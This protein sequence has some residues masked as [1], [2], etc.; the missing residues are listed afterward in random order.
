MKLDQEYILHFGL[1]G[2]TLP[3][4]KSIYLTKK[5]EVVDAYESWARDTNLLR[6]YTY[7][8][9]LESEYT[10]KEKVLSELC[11]KD[12]EVCTS[13][14]AKVEVS[15]VVRDQN[16]K[17]LSGILLEVLG[18]SFTTR[19]D[20]N[21][22]YS[23]SFEHL[24][25]AVLRLSATSDS[26]MVGIKRLDIQDQIR[27]L[28]TAQKFI[29]DFTLALP[30]ATLRI[31][32]VA[33]TITGPWTGKWDTGYTVVTPSNKYWIPFDAIVEEN[34]V[35]YQGK[36][37][38]LL[39]EFDRNTSS[40][41]LDADVFDGVE[42]FAGQTLV[43]YGMP[44]IIFMGEKGEKLHVLNT[45]PMKI[46]TSFKEKDENT[47]SGEFARLYKLAYEDSQK[48]PPNTYPIDARWEHERTVEK[49][50][51]LWWV[52]DKKSGYWN[53][54]GMRLL[55]DVFDSPYNIESIFYTTRG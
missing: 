37:K 52:Y 18:T 54:E 20:K 9:S 41:L 22:A 46:Q 23:L 25:P 33:K 21:G 10:K 17:P 29:K 19:S 27:V 53:N 28:G 13:A 51:P 26:T 7:L 34:M 1:H 38:V 43:T 16:G 39:F 24:S 4:E 42:W 49:V 12:P 2:G 47:S 11:E 15:G 44:Y 36:V 48:A 50:F 8:L 6:A 31:D 40:Y 32:T 35:Q 14:R 5:Q 3:G 45:N 30:Y 55:T